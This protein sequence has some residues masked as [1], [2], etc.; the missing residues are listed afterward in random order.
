M[1]KKETKKEWRP[2]WYPFAED[3]LPI[4]QYLLQRGWTMQ[5]LFNKAIGDHLHAA[6]VK[7][8]VSFRL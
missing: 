8:K 4:K 2:A 6:K 1:S 7:A 5:D 3:E